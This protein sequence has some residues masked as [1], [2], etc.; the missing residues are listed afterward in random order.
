MCLV[1]AV[2]LGP[3]VGVCKYR[4]TFG[5]KLKYEIYLILLACSSLV[6]NH[7]HRDAAAT[8]VLNVSVLCGSE[9]WLC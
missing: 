1:D 4:G 6:M 5:F 2:R 9:V 8:I 3:C 7:E